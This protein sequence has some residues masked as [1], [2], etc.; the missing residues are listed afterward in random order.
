MTVAVESLARRIPKAELH[1]H[2]EGTITR[3][4]YERIASRNG[5]EIGDPAMAFACVDFQSFLRCFLKV[6]LVLQTP[7]D[8]AEL[9]FDYLARSAEDN[10]RHVEFFISPATQRKF[11]PGLDLEATM[12]AIH[13]ASERA[14]AQYGITSLLIFDMVRN[15]GEASA[16][17]DIDLALRCANFGVV[18]VGLGGDEQNFPARDFQSAYARAREA[19]L[20]RT[21][22]AGEAA[23]AESIADAVRLLDAE[24]IGHGVAARR[25][26][27]I[28]AMLRD[29]AITVDACPTS[30]RITG[31][32]AKDENHPLKEFIDEGLSVTLNSDDPAFFNTTVADEYALGVQL[33]ATADD[34]VAIAKNSFTASFLPEAEKQ[35]FVREVDAFYEELGITR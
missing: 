20:R 2:L 29:R 14:R 1:V 10:V 15:L 13:E 23:G 8:F 25:D 19:G 22:H 18:G 34:I 12:E 24:R 3:V 28:R 32:V 31:A 5:I 21:V 33:G 9:A 11:V 26:P 17:D 4:A 35:R 27:E 6:V 30:N 7:K 16:M